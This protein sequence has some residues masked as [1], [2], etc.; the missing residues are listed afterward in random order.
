MKESGSK[1]IYRK[2]VKMS[3]P[4]YIMN[5]S[6][7]GDPSLCKEL[8]Q[9]SSS[10]F[11]QADNKLTLGVDFCFKTLYYRD[12]IIFLALWYMT[13]VENRFPELLKNYISGSNGAI[14][15]YDITNS[16]ELGRLPFWLK[17][18]RE[19]SRNI[20]IFLIVNKIDLGESDKVIKEEVVESTKK[21]HISRKVS[22]KIG[23][24]IEESFKS[25]VEVLIQLY[26]QK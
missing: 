7:F 11:S 17:T 5:I 12:K 24:D 9:N 22:S 8:L 21:Y 19:N 15:I 20:P 2:S 1:Q 13:E 4:D 18:I 14:I 6:L 23:Q 3:K 26:N 10:C 25:L 16:E